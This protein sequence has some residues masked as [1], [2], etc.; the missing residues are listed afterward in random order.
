MLELHVPTLSLNKDVPFSSAPIPVGGIAL[1][2]GCCTQPPPPP[3]A[4]S[5]A[6]IAGLFAA[7]GARQAGKPQP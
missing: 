7:L 5:S 3:R 6:S 2:Q 4:N 1:P